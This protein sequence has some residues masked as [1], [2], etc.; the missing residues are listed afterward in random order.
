[1]GS[2]PEEQGVVTMVAIEFH[3]DACVVQRLSSW[4]DARRYAAERRAFIL[5]R[6]AKQVVNDLMA[7]GRYSTG[8]Y[9]VSEFG[10][11]VT[12]S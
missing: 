7:T 11:W 4:H 6:Q 1:M 9:G 5:P 8:H 12:L 2:V 10:E 3:E